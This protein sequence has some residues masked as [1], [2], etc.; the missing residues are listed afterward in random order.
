MTATK[1]IFFS[2]LGNKIQ[3]AMITSLLANVCSPLSCALS[4]S[5]NVTQSW[6]QDVMGQDKLLPYWNKSQDSLVGY[7]CDL[8]DAI[9][10]IPSLL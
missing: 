2:A 7:G 8:E 10:S 9:V 1:S 5:E 3:K 6:K 4:C